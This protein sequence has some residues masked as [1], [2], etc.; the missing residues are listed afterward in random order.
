MSHRYYVFININKWTQLS[1]WTTA[2]TM[3]N[4]GEGNCNPFWQVCLPGDPWTEEPG[5][6]WSIVS[7]R[8]GQDWSNLACMRAWIIYGIYRIYYAIKVRFGFIAVVQFLSCV[9][10]LQHTRLL[11]P[12]LSPRV[13]SNS[14]SLC[15]W[16]HPTISS[17]VACFFSCPQSF[18][19]WGSFLMNWFFTSGGQSIGASPSVFLQWTC[20]VDFLQDWLVW[21][22]CSPRDS[23]ESSPALQLKSINS[24]A[25]TLLL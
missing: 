9:H 4:T 6:L 16:C 5:G 19:A 22:P 18:L 15:R 7:E 25:L 12:S 10:E 24:S 14:C 11:C 20:R 17:S 2:M 8:V 1:D 21:S 3:N 13:C 23:Q